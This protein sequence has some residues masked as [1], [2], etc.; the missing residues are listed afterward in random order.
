[1]RPQTAGDERARYI[2][3]RTVASNAAQ[4]LRLRKADVH[5]LGLIAKVFF[6][7]PH[8]IAKKPTYAFVI[9]SFAK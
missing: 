4:K 5:L 8:K 7:P 6:L 9:K 2:F 1:M 3:A